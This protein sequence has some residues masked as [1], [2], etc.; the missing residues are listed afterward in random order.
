MV[1]ASSG[2]FGLNPRRPVSR[3][4]KDPIPAAIVDCVIAVVAAQAHAGAHQRESVLRCRI[5]FGRERLF[6]AANRAAE[7]EF[8]FSLRCSRHEFQPLLHF[9]AGRFRRFK[10]D[11]GVRQ[12]ASLGV[13]RLYRRIHDPRA[14]IA[15]DQSPLSRI[16]LNRSRRV[17]R[18]L[19]RVWFGG[20]GGANQKH[21][22]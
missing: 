6:A 17:G 20:Q 22:D 19:N 14:V 4:D 11:L 10:L 18:R 16:P 21:Q 13:F 15:Q 3:A 1:P 7:H 12:N 8:H 9:V 5:G 2:V